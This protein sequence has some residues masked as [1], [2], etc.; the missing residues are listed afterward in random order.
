MNLFDKNTKMTDLVHRNYLLLPVL[1]R[2]GIRLGFQGK[3][4][5]DICR[6]E[7]ELQSFSSILIVDYLRK[8]HSEFRKVSLPKIESL[9]NKFV[10]NSKSDDLKI[11][12]SFYIKYK[13]EFLEHIM[14]EDENV[15][16]YALE[17]QKAYDLKT[18]PIPKKLLDYSIHSFEKE[19]SN[20]DE[21]LF[22]LKNII[23][24]YL[25]PNYNDKDCNEFLF[26]LFQF[27]RD[28]KDHARIEDKILTQKVMG[29]ENELKNEK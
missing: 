17:L 29:I 18:Q 19:H 23:I 10:K 16:P 6:Q 25:E 14:E 24:K 26:E 12:Q 11:I 20:L 22:D 27:E 7:N 5:D 3:T 1:N 4:I 8:S 2:F 9:L 21:K 28:L 13:E 15:F